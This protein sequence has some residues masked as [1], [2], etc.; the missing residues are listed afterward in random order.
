M[1]ALHYIM[2]MLSCDYQCTVSLT[3]SA[4]GWSVVCYCCII[5][6]CIPGFSVIQ[7]GF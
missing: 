2:F 1:A 4:T 5:L 7:S 6:S 3:D